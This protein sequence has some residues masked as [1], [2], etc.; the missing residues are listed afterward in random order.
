MSDVRCFTVKHADDITRIQ[1]DLQIP[2][3]YMRGTPLKTNGLFLQHF[4]ND[5]VFIF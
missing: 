1:C 4:E 5:A 2:C 3:G